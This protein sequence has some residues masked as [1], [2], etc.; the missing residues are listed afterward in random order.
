MPESAGA[1]ICR[2]LT[3]TP[4]E[5]SKVVE[6]ERQPRASADPADFIEPRIQWVR[7]LRRWTPLDSTLRVLD[8]EDGGTG[9]AHSL[10]VSMNTPGA[11]KPCEC[12]APR[13]PLVV[14]LT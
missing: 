11:S 1:R 10:S 9:T 13:E 12:I 7:R 2:M 6:A 5:K 4:V 8:L 3:V 14:G